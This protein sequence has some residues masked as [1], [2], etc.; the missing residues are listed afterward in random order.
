MKKHQRGHFIS[1]CPPRRVLYREGTSLCF[2]HWR[3]V[4]WK[5]CDSLSCTLGHCRG[6]FIV[7]D[8]P[9]RR[10]GAQDG[11][12]APGNS[13]LTWSLTLLQETQSTQ[14]DVAP[15]IRNRTLLWIIWVECDAVTAEMLTG[16]ICNAVLC[17][18]VTV[19][20]CVLY[21]RSLL[22]RRGIS[23]LWS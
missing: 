23:H 5:F 22:R 18:C 20:E 17:E 16:H 9:Q 4:C 14:E 7:F 11:C 10:E 13:S 2:S 3:L 12:S 21:D 15:W 1:F 6:S 8:P 19:R